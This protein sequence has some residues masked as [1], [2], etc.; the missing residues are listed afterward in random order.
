MDTVTSY[1]EAW[2]GLSVDPQNLALYQM[3]LRAVII[4]VA[5]LMMLRLGH[6]RFFARR[7]AMDVLLAFVLAS[8]LARAVNGSAAFFP[9]IGVG[10]LL[11]LLHRAVSFAASRSPF[12]GQLVK[13]T[14]T[15]LIEDGKVHE[16][17]L[18]DHA[19]SEHDLEEDL[20]LKGVASPERVERAM[21]E[22][23]GEVSVLKKSRVHTVRVEAGVQTVRIEVG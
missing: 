22:R 7:N 16:G 6:K 18:R 8:T 2:L 15:Q 11:V 19:L 23:N 5:A 4:F 17:T 14:P 20:R 3:A 1:L 12:F 10:F 21:L 13:G 9:T